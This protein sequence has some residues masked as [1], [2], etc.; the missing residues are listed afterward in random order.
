[1]ELTFTRIMGEGYGKRKQ[2]DI[3]GGQFD[4]THEQP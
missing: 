1:M 2:A 4:N 3:P